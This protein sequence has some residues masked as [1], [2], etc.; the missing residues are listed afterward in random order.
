MNDRA[1]DE[2]DVRLLPIAEAV[3][4][5]RAAHDAGRLAQTVVIAAD[6]A[7]YERLL[8]T[9][10]FALESETVSFPHRLEAPDPSR[11]VRARPPTAIEPARPRRPKRGTPERG[12]QLLRWSGGVGLVVCLGAFGMAVALR[13]DIEKDAQRDPMGFMFSGHYRESL[14]AIRLSEYGGAVALVGAAI[15]GAALVAGIAV[16][17]GRER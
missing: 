12:G 4:T 1:P 11:V 16:G 14:D 8:R 15:S 7:H 9:F 5:L 3:R 6:R 10:R 13:L 2:T 17:V